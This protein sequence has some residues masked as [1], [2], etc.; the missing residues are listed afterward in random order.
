MSASMKFYW[1]PAA[2]VCLHCCLW[3]LHAT[4]AELSSCKG[5]CMTGKADPWSKQLWESPH[6]QWW[7]RQAGLSQSRPI[8]STCKWEKGA[9]EKKEPLS[10]PW[11]WIRKHAIPTAT[12]YH[13][14]SRRGTRVKVTP[15]LRMRAEKQKEHESPKTFQATDHTTSGMIISHLFKGSEFLIVYGS[16][17]LVSVP[18]V[19]TY[20][21]EWKTTDHC[22]PKQTSV[23]FMGISPSLHLITVLMKCLLCDTLQSIFV[24]MMQV[25]LPLFWRWRK[26]KDS[27]RG[28][29]TLLKVNHE[30]QS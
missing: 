18:N 27:K 3:L 1:N 20:K 14:G 15:M 17:S 12:G 21:Q 25:L 10:S 16:L 4:V 13:P 30:W 28:P 19:G 24:T 8:S 23:L 26:V 22:S 5:E 6:S 29:M 7:L 11:T 9:N 2:A